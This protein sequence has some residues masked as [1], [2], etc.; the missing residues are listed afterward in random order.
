MTKLEQAISG[1]GNAAFSMR[2]RPGLPVEFL[3]APNPFSAENTVQMG[4]IIH[5]DDYQPFCEVINEIVNG[6]E[7]E[8]RVHARI[9]TDGEYKWYFIS[10][11]AQRTADGMLSEL[12][13]MMFDVSAYLDCDGDD[14]VMARYRSKSRHSLT[15]AQN[16]PPLIDILGE[17]YLVR[18]QQP[19]AHIKGLFSAIVDPD[20]KV[21]AAA[22]G[23]DKRAN[24]NK[25]SYQRKKNIRVKHQPVAAWVIAGESQEAVDSNAQLLETMVK[26]VSGIA[27]SYVVLGEEMDNSQNANKMLGQNF[28][29]QIL[30]NNIY[31]LIL[32]SPDTKSSISGIIPLICDYFSLDDIMFYSGLSAS[33]KVYRWDESGMLL[34]VVTGFTYNEAVEKELD[35]SSVVFADEKNISANKN[36][37]RSF[38]MS[39]TYKNG[40]KSGVIVYISKN[41]DQWNNRSRKLL[42]TITQIL[43]TVI[44]K[45]IIEAELEQSQEHLARL[46]YYDFTTNI[47][48][49]SMFEKDFAALIA[50]G[51]SGAVISAEISNLKTI[52]EIYSCE[53]ADDIV[54]SIAE[55]ISAIP[56]TSQK[57][58]Y[59]FSNDILFITLTGCNAEEARQLAQAILTKFRSPWYLR[60]TEHHL[61]IYAGVTTYPEDAED[62]LDCIKAAT[63]TLRLAKERRLGDAVFY[64]DGLEEQLSDNLR[65]KKLIIDAAENEFRGFYLLYTP[66]LAVNSGDLHCCEANLFWGND[67]IIVSRERFLPIIDRLGLSIEM[68]RYVIDR[69]CEFCATVRENG[70]ENFRVSYAVPENILNSDACV[71][72]LRG[73]LLEYSL[74]PTAV[75]ISVS[76]SAGT[77]NTGNMFLQQLAKIGV[78]I[79]ADD[80]GESFFTTAPLH[81]PAVKTVKIRADRFKG[82]PISDMFMRSVINLAHEKDI[83]VCI[84]GVDN[85]EIFGKVRKFDIDLVEGIFNGRPLHSTEF[86]GRLV[87][88]GAAVGK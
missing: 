5:P 55:Y 7:N 72:A 41:S 86:L 15:S 46:A 48:N 78:N 67:D 53:Y 24:L 26:T 6:S 30:I 44:N 32:Q 8:L 80:M 84:R 21:I 12:D 85:A 75:S 81:N 18:I 57:K 31:S 74:P 63:R 45:S 33:A 88:G 22:S 27:N 16:T 9:M 76:E 3:S 71:E 54:R 61:E 20:G 28:E 19:F 65:V 13:G 4:E 43:S 42:K 34:P 73:S 10:A 23:Q 66:I 87:A 35:Y 29:D 77:L 83:S 59:R 37:T 58:V 60:D 62:I 2:F 17:D 1:S 50:D 82:D 79:I 39:L 14:A 40:Q 11:T 52:S 49:R 68:Y 64:S 25:M 70:F 56:C 36:G 38:A 51:Q 69:I 47:P